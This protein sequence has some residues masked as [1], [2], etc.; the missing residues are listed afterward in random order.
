MFTENLCLFNCFSVLVILNIYCDASSRLSLSLCAPICLLRYFVVLMLLMMLRL[1]LVWS[2]R[3]ECACARV[4]RG[5]MIFRMGKYRVSTEALQTNND[6]VNHGAKVK[7]L[8]ACVIG[9]V[10]HDSLAIY[11]A[12]ITQKKKQK[13]Q[14]HIAWRWHSYLISICFPRSS[15]LHTIRCA[16]ELCASDMWAWQSNNRPEPIATLFLCM[17]IVQW[18]STLAKKRWHFDIFERQWFE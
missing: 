18:T 13:Q 14:P 8:F 12:R 4:H 5:K 7:C 17:C 9:L 1:F 3:C 16:I 6:S 2:D 15:Y 11:V 10:G